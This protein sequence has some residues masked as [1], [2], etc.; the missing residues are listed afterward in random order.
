MNVELPGWKFRFLTIKQIL[1]FSIGLLF[2]MAASSPVRT[3]G[4]DSTEH[5]QNVNSADNSTRTPIKHVIVIIGENRTFDHLFATYKPKGN[6]TIWNLRSEGIVNKDGTPG[7]NYSLAAQSSAT[8][9]SP[10]TFQE[11]PMGKS[12]LSVLPVPLTGGPTNPPYSTVAQAM[13]AENG[14][15]SRYYTF[16]TTGGTGQASNVPDA[17]ISYNGQNAASLPD[18]P[19]QLTP[20]VPYDSYA[21]SPVQDRRERERRHLTMLPTGTKPL[22]AAVQA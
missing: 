12:L 20:G 17:R 19:F 7:P 15:A 14:L 18:G 5:G 10:D 22:G 11:S 21:A 9:Q 16:L 8:D 13:A 4:Q 6:Q 2:L 3:N 1:C